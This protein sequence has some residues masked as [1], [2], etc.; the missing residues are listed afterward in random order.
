M[1]EQSV[2]L[3]KL[4]KCAGC[5]CE[6][7]MAIPA[8]SPM[9][10][11]VYQIQFG[12]CKTDKDIYSALLNDFDM[13]IEGYIYI[14]F[15]VA[16]VYEHTE[17]VDAAKAPTCTETGLT[18]GSH[19]SVCDEILVAQVVL[20]SNGHSYG[21]WSVVKEPTEAE[22]GIKIRECD[23]CD[24][25]ETENIA[26]L[27]HNHSSWSVIVL[28]AIAPTCTTPGLTEGKKC[29]GCGETLVE[30]QTVPVIPHVGEIVSGKAATCT[31]TGLTDG[32]K[33]TACGATLVAQTTIKAL[34]HT[35]VVDEGK[36]A[37]CTEAGITTGKHCSACN[38]VIIAQET[39]AA[40]GHDMI[41]D[42]AKAPTCT[43][44][45]LT[46][47]S[48]CTRC[49]HKVAQETIPALG[50]TFIGSICYVCYGANPDFIANN[51][52]AGENKVV[53]NEH[54]LVANG[55]GEHGFPYEFPFFVVTE[56]GHYTFTSDKP[57][58]VFIYTTEVSTEGA[59]WTTGGA[60]WNAFV[61]TEADLQPGTY[62]IGF[63][64][65]SGVGEYNVTV[66]RTDIE[67]PHEHNFVEGKCE[68]GESDPNY[69][70]PH[71]HNFVEGKCECG[72]SDPDYVA[73]EQP[74]QPE[75][76][77]P[78]LN[79]FQ[80]IWKAITDF[81]QKVGNVFTNFFGKVGNFF[82]NLFGGKK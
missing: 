26:K 49:D 9:F 48:H 39:I 79:F 40:L 15:E 47:G 64:Y 71:T 54:H 6:L 18:A 44:A 29:S 5:G 52:V 2:K 65:I 11:R 75:E 73:P 58:S 81:F 25:Y 70:P 82:T 43:E 31:E 20:G 68:C 13:V 62:Y 16:H 38:E 3:T 17:V 8:L 41:D 59:D 77:Q 34:G 14:S 10:M 28:E 23:N 46:A 36:A 72:E 33:C 19:C 50:H 51:V 22:D 42:A 61:L 66:T 21:N 12:T 78:E 56:A 4:A 69:V 67:V 74:E 7:T 60:A 53:V 76:E 37:T 35:E 45:G 55:E 24:A 57:I 80:K 27:S 63:I 1:A 32:K 30:Q